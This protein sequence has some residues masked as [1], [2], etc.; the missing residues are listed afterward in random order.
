MI[1][2]NY[3]DVTLRQ[4]LLF[5]RSIE[6][7]DSVRTLLKEMSRVAFNHI[8]DKLNANSIS[9]NKIYNN[10]GQVASD[11]LENH[12]VS[13][14]IYKNYC[15][16][17][18]ERPITGLIR[19]KTNKHDDMKWILTSNGEDVFLFLDLVA[20]DR[21]SN[22]CLIFDRK[23]MYFEQ[24]SSQYLIESIVKYGFKTEL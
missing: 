6:R 20:H 3:Q 13:L 10:A 4:Y 5:L 9:Y 12:C 1:V 19:D 23:N 18:R 7:T 16:K 8:W 11:Y 15:K 21:G 14:V 22:Q 24:D 17:L 2:Q